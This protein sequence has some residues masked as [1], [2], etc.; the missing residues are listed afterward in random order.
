M[1]E[2]QIRLYGKYA[3]II[4]KYSKDKQG[5]DEQHYLIDNNEGAE[6]NVYIFENILQCYMCAAMLGIINKKTMPQDSNREKTANIFADI[7]AKNRH[8]LMRIYQHMIL[9]EENDESIDATV[10]KAFSINISNPDFAQE[11]MDSYV[12]GGLLII[13]EWFNNCK[14]YE[15]LANKIIDFVY[16]YGIT[17]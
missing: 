11:K 6:N 13:D 2:K 5:S 12:R 15:D 7:L 8:N 1:F 10:K 17:E 14:S 4:R 16:E 3:D 9:S